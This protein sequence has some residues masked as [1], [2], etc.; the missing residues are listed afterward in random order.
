M[1]IFDEDTL[2]KLERL[3]LIADQVRVGVMK[4]DRRSHKH[5]SSTEFA[6][7]RNYE[8]GDDLR[9]LDWN[10]FAR[11]ER[12]FVKLLEDEEELA[13]HI[14]IDT[15]ASMDWPENRPHNKY[16]YS[17]KLAAA[18][19]HIALSSGDLLSIKTLGDSGQIWGPF[20]GQRNSLYLFQYL[21]QQTSGGLTNL[22]QSLKDYA[23]WAKRPGFLFLISDLFSP[24]GHWPGI[25]ALLARGYEISIIQI[26]SPDEIDPQFEGDLRLVDSE[27]GKTEEVSFDAGTHQAYRRHLQDWQ[28]ETAA[29]CHQRGVHYIPVRTDFA[30]DALIQQSMRG[31]GILK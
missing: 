5:G 2:R 27:T 19:G 23:R 22:N 1:E 6:D 31:Q 28:E 20:R 7:Y 15:S 24:E 25:N 21:D 30:W 12:P 9:R 4:G 29:I 16:H 10:I 13:V 3:T 18:L 11:L 17:L 8:R 26:L 14:L